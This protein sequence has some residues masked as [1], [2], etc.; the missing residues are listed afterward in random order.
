MDIVVP[1]RLTG[2]ELRPL[3]GALVGV[4]IHDGGRVEIK[5]STARRAITLLRIV[6]QCVDADK[7]PTPS[8]R[9]ADVHLAHVSPFRS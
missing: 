9:E 1:D 7:F 8:A 2:I 5:C 3:I 6:G 4:A